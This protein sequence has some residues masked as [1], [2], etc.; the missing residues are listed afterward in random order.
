MKHKTKFL[1]FILLIL[2]FT[3][4]SL[5]A[6]TLRISDPSNKTATTMSVDNNADSFNLEVWIT[7]N[8][9]TE[10]NAAA[11]FLDFDN[12]ILTLNA[13]TPNLSVF[14]D[15]FQN[16]Y[17]DTFF[18]YNVVTTDASTNADE[19]LLATLNF[20]PTELGEVNFR[21]YTAADASNRQSAV[22]SSSSFENV[23][24]FS[25]LDVTVAVPEIVIYPLVSAWAEE[26]HYIGSSG[27]TVSDTLVLSYEMTRNFDDDDGII[28]YLRTSGNSTST[29]FTYDGKTHSLP[30]E[31]N[32]ALR[33]EPNNG[34]LISF[35]EVDGVGNWVAMDPQPNWSGSG[36]EWDPGRLN[37]EIRLG[38]LGHTGGNTIDVLATTVNRTDN[39]LFG[40]TPPDNPLSPPEEDLTLTHYWNFNL[41]TGDSSVIDATADVPEAF[42]AITTP[43]TGTDFAVGEITVSGTTLNS[44]SGDTVRI[45]V[46]GSQQTVIDLNAADQSFSD[47]ITLSIGN[48]VIT[49]ELY[50]NNSDSIAVDSVEV[51]YT[52]TT[53]E[54]TGVI[55]PIARESGLRAG[56]SVGFYRVGEADSVV[57]TTTSETGAFT[58]TAPADE[59][60]YIRAGGL[61]HLYENF[62]TFTVSED[63]NVGT[64]ELNRAGD[65]DGN[66]MINI[67]D[68]S[69]VRAEDAD[70]RGDEDWAENL[71]Y[72]RDNFGE[73]GAAI[74]E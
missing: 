61:F 4:F 68:A 36:V 67:F 49:A 18:N 52:P 64:L 24:A 10:V 69:R 35:L 11:V 51:T 25:E 45:L 15:T 8:S 20:T 27:S 31:F 9:G 38:D 14:G 19:I 32:Y 34:P 12:T 46:N 72:V 5:S 43:D 44:L 66:N 21:F 30:V 73:I 28:Y 71:N 1:F 29:S 55:A 58:L 40:V 47:S 7:D 41:L 26:T 42:I 56:V 63:T 13:V 37:F 48:N 17:S 16:E 33:V 3:A 2:C 74:K 60:G 53:W 62:V 23:A 57:G 22:V 6:T 70:I 59:E 65:A 54:I 39:H 50:Y